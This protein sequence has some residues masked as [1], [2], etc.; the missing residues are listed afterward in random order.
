MLPTNGSSATE[1]EG[2]NLSCNPVCNMISECARHVPGLQSVSK[3]HI[4]S[5]T[6]EIVK[7]GLQL[8]LKISKQI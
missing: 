6:L 4:E 3:E 8:S 7:A 1:N 5:K 2:G